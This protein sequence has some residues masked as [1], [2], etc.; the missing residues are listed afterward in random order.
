MNADLAELVGLYEAMHACIG[1]EQD[2][3]DAT[4][5]L[6][7][8]VQQCAAAKK[9]SFEVVMRYV[10]ER[11]HERARAEEKRKKLPPPPK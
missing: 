7:A 8:A 2:R 5:A 3:T 1:S 4:R 9:L 6:E 11:Y 10:K